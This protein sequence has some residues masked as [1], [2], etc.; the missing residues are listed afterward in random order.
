MGNTCNIRTVEAEVQTDDVTDRQNDTPVDVQVVN[1]AACD[2]SFSD[3][4]YH[5]DIR[6]S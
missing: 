2:F 1:E 4:D 6:Q 5:N 3:S